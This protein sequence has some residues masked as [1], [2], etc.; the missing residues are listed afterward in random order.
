MYSYWP[1]QCCRAGYYY[2]CQWL[3]R[4]SQER[5]PARGPPIGA[6]LPRHLLP[7]TPLSHLPPAIPH[8]SGGARAS[9][10][11]R[12][13]GPPGTRVLHHRASPVPRRRAPQCLRAI[14]P[15]E[16][17]RVLKDKEEKLFGEY[18][19]RRLVLAAWARQH[20]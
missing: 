6:A 10:R 4:P 17:F 5:G 13:P 2:F 14:L 11:R 9:Q 18:R 20:E 16:T 3:P 1:T 19:T 7:A 12:R 8:G 15:S